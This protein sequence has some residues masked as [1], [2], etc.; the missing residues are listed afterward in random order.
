[1]QAFRDFKEANQ[2]KVSRKQ[3][4]GPEIRQRT[5]RRRAESDYSSEAAT[6]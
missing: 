1:M 2:P 6:N 5:A 3:G 4:E